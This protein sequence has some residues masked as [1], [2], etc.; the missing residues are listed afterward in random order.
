MSRKAE[1][2]AL[3]V[4]PPHRGA[5]D[6][7]IKAH[8]SGCS[9]FIQGYDYGVK[10]LLTVENIKRLDEIMTEVYKQTGLRE[11]EEIYTEVIKRFKEEQKL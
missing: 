9:E 3:T 7:W 8:L 6:E 5:S 2:T 10:E 11:D 1:I 4:F